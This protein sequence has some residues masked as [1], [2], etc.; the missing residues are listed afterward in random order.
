[1]LY[2]QANQGKTISADV[3]QK[4][5]ASILEKWVILISNSF[6]LLHTPV[7]S[8]VTARK[9][10]SHLILFRYMLVDSEE[11]KKVHRP[12]TPKDVS[13]WCQF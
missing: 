12:V 8:D 4:L 1:M 10:K 3:D 5:K 7:I 13:F 11:D 6:K 9:K 2:F